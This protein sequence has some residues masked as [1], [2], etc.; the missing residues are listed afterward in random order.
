M[1]EHHHHHHPQ[2]HAHPPAAI[3]PSILRMSVGQRLA[4]AAV[5]IGLIWAAVYWAMH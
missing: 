4:A 1:T 2:G 3:A 5:L